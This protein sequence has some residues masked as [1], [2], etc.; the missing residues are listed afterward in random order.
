MGVATWINEM[1]KMPLP[2][3]FLTRSGRVISLPP[4]PLGTLDTCWPPGFEAEEMQLYAGV[5]L[6]PPAMPCMLPEAAFSPSDNR[7]DRDRFLDPLLGFLLPRGVHAL[8]VP[9]VYWIV[10]WEPGRARRNVTS[11]DMVYRSGLS[12]VER[13]PDLEIISFLIS[14]SNVNGLR[15][16]TA[17]SWK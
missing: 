13:A 3:L 16:D 12:W 5:A 4:L 11:A 14:A 15:R 1:W 9:F 6:R 8:K 10:S 17:R 7:S 2:P